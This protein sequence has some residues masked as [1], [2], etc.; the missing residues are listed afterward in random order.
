MNQPQRDQWVYFAILALL[1][2]ITIII[3]VLVLHQEKSKDRNLEG[4]LEWCFAHGAYETPEEHL[5]CT[6]RCQTKLLEIA[7][8][9]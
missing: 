3:L 7:R 6:E 9:E 8:D 4:C 2:A 5:D 1:A